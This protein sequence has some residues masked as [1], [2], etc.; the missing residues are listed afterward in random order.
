MER[1]K[2]APGGILWDEAQLV[3]NMDSSQS[4]PSQALQKEPVKSLLKRTQLDSGLLDESMLE[5]SLHQTQ[6]VKKI[7]GQGNTKAKAK[8]TK[9]K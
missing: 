6:V 2:I 9:K 7:A 4:S 1:N 5:V 3:V 8:K